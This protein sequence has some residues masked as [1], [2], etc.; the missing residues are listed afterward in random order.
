[1]LTT[2]IWRLRWGWVGSGFLLLVWSFFE[3]SWVVW[4]VRMKGDDVDVQEI[5]WNTPLES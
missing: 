5:P 3:V 1:M 2:T 4:L